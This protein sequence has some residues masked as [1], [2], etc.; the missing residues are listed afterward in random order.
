M[1][2]LLCEPHFETGTGTQTTSGLGSKGFS[3]LAILAA[4]G[5]KGIR[6]ERIA[7]MVW[8]NRDD[9]QAKSTLRQ[10]LT[11][12][13]K[14]LADLPDVAIET[15]GDVVCLSAP[16]QAVDIRLFDAAGPA[17][18]RGKI[19]TER[20]KDLAALYRGEFM[21][22]FSFDGDLLAHMLSFRQRYHDYALMLAE[23]LS[24]QPDALDEAERLAKTLVSIDPAAE[25]AYRAL[26]RVALAH[27]KRNRA[28]KHLTTLKSVLL[29]ELGAD[30]E[31]ETLA[32]LDGAEQDPPA[33]EAPV[34][35]PA[36]RPPTRTPGD[37][38]PTALHRDPALRRY[39]P[40]GQRFP[41]RRAG[42]RDHGRAVADARVLRHRPPIRLCLQG[43]VHRRARGG[44]GAGCAL[45]HRRHGAAGR[46]ACPLACAACRRDHRHD[47]LGAAV[48]QRLHRYAGPPA[49]GRPPGRRGDPALGPKPR[50]RKDPSPPARVAQRLRVRVAGLSEILGAP[51][52]RKRRGDRAARRRHR[53]GTDLR[54]CPRAQG[55]VPRPDGLLPLERDARDAS[56]R[57][58]RPR[59]HR[60][61]A[62]RRGRNRPGRH[63][64]RLFDGDAR[65]RAGPAFHRLQPR[66]RP[67]NAWAWMRDGWLHVLGHDPRRASK[68]SPWQKGSARSIRSCSTSIS[69]R[70]WRGRS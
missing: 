7:A 47:D 53:P 60:R 11:A 45:Y 21:S 49:S 3:V 36:A 68:A 26:I 61:R 42:E 2:R 67:C 4:A 40:V 50:D 52:R 16:D 70:P 1:I 33:A 9:L 48:R 19:G 20:A 12:I 14:A 17:I 63:R 15:S 22:G 56:R 24:Q 51:P 10:V 28:L 57:R 8:P 32:L 37:G 35:Q 65:T 64:C 31:T 46:G 18:T 30:P 54:A 62:L 38:E 43:P 34:A 5:A 41:R 55:L 66:H 39:Q 58:H 29:E 23:H 6:R 59:P 27:G 25:E 69:D 44:R 13:R